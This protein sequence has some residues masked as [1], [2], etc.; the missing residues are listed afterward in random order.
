MSLSKDSKIRV[1]KKNR[2]DILFFCFKVHYPG[3]RSTQE[4][5]FTKTRQMPFSPVLTYG[6]GWEHTGI[7]THRHQIAQILPKGKVRKLLHALC[8]HYKALVEEPTN[9]V[10]CNQ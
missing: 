4:T 7:F 1:L 3:G 9:D 6:P 8:S 5:Q 2:T 10:D